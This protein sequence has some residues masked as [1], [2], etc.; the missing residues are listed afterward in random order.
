MVSFWHEERKALDTQR[1]SPVW[2]GAYTY[3]SSS[4]GTFSITANGDGTTVT[5]P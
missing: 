5:V 2:S 1:G 4:T 3:T